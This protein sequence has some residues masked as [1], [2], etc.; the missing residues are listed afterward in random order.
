MLTLHVVTELV[1]F[2]ENT[3]NYKIIQYDSYT[4]MVGTVASQQEGSWFEFR[5]FL[6]LSAWSLN[7]L[8]VYAWVLSG[9]SRRPPTAQKHAC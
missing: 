6:R 9:Y 2:S 1:S 7:V 8:P 3:K 5:A 4:H